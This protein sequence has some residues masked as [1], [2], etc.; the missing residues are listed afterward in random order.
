[1]LRDTLHKSNFS[2]AAKMRHLIRFS[3][4]GPL[5]WITLVCLWLNPSPLLAQVQEK[6]LPTTEYLIELENLAGKCDELNLPA[7]AERT[8]TWWPK[9]R[10]DQTWLVFPNAS[11][12]S[13]GA[14]DQD[15][16]RKWQTRFETLR[17]RHALFL[18][19]EIQKSLDN[20][21]E[22]TAYRWAW[23]AH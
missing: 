2:L 16:V 4:N 17:R 5:V 14:K 21:D 9:T 22:I 7:E 8:R 23:R 6:P 10:A 19:E 3:S 15:L 18:L 1:M 13:A 11:E 12:L 20:K